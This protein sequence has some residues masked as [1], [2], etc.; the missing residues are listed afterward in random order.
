MIIILKALQC[1][2]SFVNHPIVY[3]LY[4][5]VVL[6]THYILSKV[7]LSNIAKTYLNCTEKFWGK[8]TFYCLFLGKILLQLSAGKK[9]NLLDVP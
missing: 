9:F 5:K 8:F 4:P 3:L 2:P 1:N 6:I 7:F